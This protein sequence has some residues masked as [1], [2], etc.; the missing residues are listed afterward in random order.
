VK[1]MLCLNRWHWYSVPDALASAIVI[2]TI[3]TVNQVK[4]G[5]AAYGGDLRSPGNSTGLPHCRCDGR[6]RLCLQHLLGDSNALYPKLCQ[7]TD[8][9][10]NK[11]H[12][13]RTEA[14][15]RGELVLQ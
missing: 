1:R 6:S 8:S 13:S 2:T 11:G 4:K 9:A 15:R 3:L 5:G 10:M 14:L 7:G 12:Y